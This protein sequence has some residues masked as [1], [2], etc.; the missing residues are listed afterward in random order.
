MAAAFALAI[1]SGISISLSVN[2]KSLRTFPVCFF[3]ERAVTG[4]RW[5]SSCCICRFRL[6]SVKMRLERPAGRDKRQIKINFPLKM[7]KAHAAG[8]PNR[9]AP[10][11]VFCA[12]PK[13]PGKKQAHLPLT[14][15]A[16]L[17]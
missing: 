17:L 2:Q 8:I 9:P 15:P 13:N 1:F 10:P 4:R 14:N 11:G 16:A 5:F 6:Q 7:P 12:L 3:T